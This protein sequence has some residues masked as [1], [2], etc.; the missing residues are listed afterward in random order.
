MDLHILICKLMYSNI[1]LN[2]RFTQTPHLAKQFFLWRFLLLCNVTHLYLIY[3]F[4]LSGSR[5][6]NSATFG[7]NII[8][9]L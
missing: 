3:H 9:P 6:N 5:L 8:G 1:Y 7:L 2:H 4:L